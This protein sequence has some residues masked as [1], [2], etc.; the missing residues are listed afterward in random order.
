MSLLKIS[1]S[2]YPDVKAQPMQI[3][4]SRRIKKTKSRPKNWILLLCL[5]PRGWTKKCSFK[6]VSKWTKE[7]QKMGVKVQ[8]RASEVSTN[9]KQWLS[10]FSKGAKA[11]P[12]LWDLSEIKST[13]NKR[14]QPSKI[15]VQSIKMKKLL[16]VKLL[17]R[18][19]LAFSSK[20]QKWRK[21]R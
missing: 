6:E 10:Q 21:K 20:N 16:T 7:T 13:L 18:G 12:S 4:A 2:S 8:R 11:L 9:R 5:A 3:D 15:V 17:L 19:C 1:G 14:S